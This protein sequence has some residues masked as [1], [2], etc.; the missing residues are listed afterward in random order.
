[1]FRTL[2][3]LL[4]LAV[5]G[6][7]AQPAIRHGVGIPTRDT[8]RILIVFAEVDFKD[9]PCP[10][11][12]TE[13]F[14]GSWPRDRQG[15]TQPPT[16]AGAFLDRE[17]AADGQMD[18]FITRYY[19]EAS[20]GSYILLGDYLPE[21]VTIPCKD[22]RVGNHGLTQILD[23][24]AAMRPQDTTL[25]TAGGYPLSAFDIWSAGKSG[26][27]KLKEPDGS[28]DLLYIIWR[29]NRMLT[30]V[31]TIDY[32]GFGV[33]GARG[34]PFKDM[35]GVSNMASFNASGAPEKAMHITVAEHLHGI[36]G[37][38]HWHSAGG[39]GMHT[40]LMPGASY[41]LTA[42]AGGT[43]LAASGWDRWMMDWMHP[44]KQFTIS[45]L[46]ADGEEVETERI[47]IDTHPDGGIFILRD[48]MATG[49][50]MRI[51]LPF[52]DWEKMGD[53]KNQYIWLENRRMTTD[54]DRYL[55]VEC[56]NN[57]D[58]RFPRGTPG[59]YAYVQVGKDM[60]EGDG[61]YS[62]TP[63]HPN[64]LAS[65]FLPLPAEG[66][67]DFH[68][69]YDRIQS[70]DQG[71]NCNWGNENIPKDMRRSRPNPLTGMSDLYSQIDY[72]RDGKMYSGDRIYTGLSKMRGDSAVHDYH[73]NGDWLDAFAPS[74]GRMEM[75]LSTNPAPLPVYTYGSNLEFG[76]YTIR[77]SVLPGFENRVIH[78][79]GLSL[80]F[81]E[82]D[83]GDMQVSFRW[84]DYE[85]SDHVR[86]CGTIVQHP[87]L[88]DISLPSLKV[89]QRRRLLLERGET[90]QYHEAREKDRRGNWLFADPTEYT[91]KQGAVMELENRAHVLVNDDSSLIFEPGSRLVLNDRSRIVVAKGAT[92]VIPDGAEVSMGKGARIVRK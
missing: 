73:M 30:S 16:F 50:A 78:L 84:D 1:M 18:G 9:G 36:F 27:P 87:H 32:A 35:Q 63:E 57:G 89:G 82:L 70:G 71:Q 45:A 59:I 53:V 24:L 67:F 90:P 49:D 42:Q 48:H 83:N 22:I 21:V 47:S 23:R 38:N 68:F 74:T 85:L 39:R 25:L 65:P 4:C 28:I 15:R 33:T 46:N 34:K 43:M 41:G 3:L 69:R 77:D 62:S 37:G 8:L 5:Q 12:L 91:V 17:I 72:N 13:D 66:R 51:K 55:A 11:N 20:F 79:N 86:W 76:R 54:T 7:M 64:G 19:H 40:F 10:S 2:V 14:A 31:N 81:N 58:G 26:Q 29:N 56:A 6:A 61:I 52:I 92:L 80:K 88:K 44:D 75:S 60:R